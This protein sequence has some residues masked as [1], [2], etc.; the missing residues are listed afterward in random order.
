MLE[1][2]E[3]ETHKQTVLSISCSCSTLASDNSSAVSSK[4]T[5]TR[6]DSV[7]A[8]THLKDIVLAREMP[9]LS[10][11]TTRNATSQS[12]AISCHWL[13]IAHES[14]DKTQS[15]VPRQSASQAEPCTQYPSLLFP[16]SSTAQ[17]LNSL[18]YSMLD[19]AMDTLEIIIE[20][21]TRI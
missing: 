17:Q 21:V 4:A 16:S 1:Q 11:C 2:L 10:S 9:R 5:C 20:L 15:F 13:P 8:L 7:T 14:R 6:W 18:A 12:L 19:V 3:E